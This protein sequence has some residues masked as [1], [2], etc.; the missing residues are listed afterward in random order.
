MEMPT[1]AF[2]R[3]ISQGQPQIGLWLSLCSNI[4]AEAM[5]YSGYD[6]LLIDTE[7]TPNNPASVLTQ[8]QA[9][10]TGTATPIVRPAWNDTVLIKGYLDIGAQSFL[11]P[12]VESAEEAQAAVEAVRYPPHGMRG[13]ATSTRGNKFGRVKDYFEKADAEICL[14]IQV[15]TQKGYDNLDEILAVEG[16]DGV[17]VGPSDLSAG[18]GHLNNPL[19]PDVQA[20]IF[21]INKRCMAAG[22]PAGILT[23][24]E[25]E[26]KAYL[27]AGFTFVAIGSDLGLMI[28]NGDALV[29]RFKQ[30]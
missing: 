9:V 6:W 17:F 22:K 3:A 5:A 12:Y 13:V 7:H 20:A 30:V 18:L 14:L 23:P 4:G 27:E 10:A 26:A 1:N 15:E 24:V 21:D 2:K 28:K 29:R 25:D 11:V 19:H 16:V 8:L